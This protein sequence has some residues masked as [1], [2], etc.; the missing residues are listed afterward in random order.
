MIHPEI[1]TIIRRTEETIPPTF[2]GKGGLD[3]II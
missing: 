1:T 2:P 3:P